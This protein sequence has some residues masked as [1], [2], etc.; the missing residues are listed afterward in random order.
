MKP[1][2]KPGEVNQYIDDM[3]KEDKINADTAQEVK[4]MLNSVMDTNDYMRKLQESSEPSWQE[5][6][7]K[8]M[9]SFNRNQARKKLLGNPDT[10]EMLER[11]DETKELL[12]DYNIKY[13]FID[14]E[15]KKGLVW[16]EKE[17]LWFSFRNNETFKN[18]YDKDGIEIWEYI[19]TK[20]D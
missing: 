6:L 7:L 5:E 16:N 20:D 11:I 8:R 12:D 19:L 9:T 1:F 2:V 4:D 13:I 15:M 10:Y 14:N 18:L 17:G 3:V